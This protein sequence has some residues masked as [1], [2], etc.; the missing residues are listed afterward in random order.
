VE[1]TGEAEFRPRVADLQLEKPFGE[2]HDQDDNQRQKW[3]NI[4]V[5]VSVDDLWEATL[6]LGGGVRGAKGGPVAVYSSS[7]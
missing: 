2:S 5:F 6:R 1:K 7:P 3:G 4:V